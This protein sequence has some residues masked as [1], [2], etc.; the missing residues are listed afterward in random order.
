VGVEW[1]PGV[2]TGRLLGFLGFYRGGTG[3]SGVVRTF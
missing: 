3:L 1:G 2:V